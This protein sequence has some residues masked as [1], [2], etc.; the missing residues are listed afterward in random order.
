MSFW[1]FVAIIVVC[2]PIA[3]ALAV[4]IRRGDTGDPAALGESRERLDEMEQRLEDTAEQLAEME[5]R[6]DFTERMLAQ[7]K[8]RQQLSP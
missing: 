2:S 7:Q 4:R 8:S 1:L 5:E 6:I 3:K